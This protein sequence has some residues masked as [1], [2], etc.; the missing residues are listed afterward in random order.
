[1]PHQPVVEPWWTPWAGVGPGH[2]LLGDLTGLTV[3]E[4]GCGN[5]DNAAALASAGGEVTG[6]D[7]DLA[8]LQRAR[9]CWRGVSQLT[10]EH[11]DAAIWL[12]SLTTPVDVVCSIF[13]ALSFT[14]PEPLLDLIAGCLP[15]CG[16]LALS[17]RTP[18]TTP[19]PPAPWQAH[20][21]TAAEWTRLL[22]ERA[23]QVTKSHMLNHLTARDAAGCIIH[24]ARRAGRA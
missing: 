2:D 4:L 9:W 12:A 13:G 11:A 18:P 23:L 21:R 7:N 1:M 16:R 10:F 22:A 24:V 15:P 8:K 17:A 14:P 20:A 5:G 3:V 19:Q 6:I